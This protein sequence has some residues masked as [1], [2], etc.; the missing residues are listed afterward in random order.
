MQKNP[1]WVKI[2]DFGI[3]KSAKNDSGKTTHLRTLAGTEGYMAPEI[4]GLLD[5]EREDSSYTCA[6]DIWSLG[7]FLYYILTKTIPFSYGLLRDLCWGL[8][9]FPE[10]SLIDKGVSWSDRRFIKELLALQP[11]QRPQ[12][13]GGISVQLVYHGKWEQHSH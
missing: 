8:S 13:S 1:I 7:C 6:V 3:R 12:A 11:Y 10:S 5:D 9:T 2:G 4:L